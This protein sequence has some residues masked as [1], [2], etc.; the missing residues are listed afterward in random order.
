MEQQERATT[1][2]PFQAATDTNNNDTQ[3]SPMAQISVDDLVGRT[4]LNQPADN[5]THQRLT[6]V[7]RINDMENERNNDPNMI[8]FR[9]Q[10]N[11][12]SLSEV[13]THNQL[14]GKIE[15]EDG[16]DEEWIFKEK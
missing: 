13:K 8:T 12:E 2:I 6:I 1:D 5:G 7:E 10:N 14:M 15:S 16:H 11:D 4:Y 3:P 9:A